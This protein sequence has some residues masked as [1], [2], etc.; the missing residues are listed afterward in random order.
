MLWKRFESETTQ[1][2][3]NEVHALARIYMILHPLGKGLYSISANYSPDN[4]LSN[5]IIILVESFFTNLD[6][7]ARNVGRKEKM[8]YWEVSRE[9]VKK[10]YVDKIARFGIA[11]TSFTLNPHNIIHNKNLSCQ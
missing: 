3:D 11:R 6:I 7:L 1:K 5:G 9:R 8:P 4:L 2:I 10:V